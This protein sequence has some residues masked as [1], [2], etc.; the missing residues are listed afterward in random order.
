MDRMRWLATGLCV[1]G[2]AG[3]LW[4]LN[5]FAGQLYPEAKP[6]KLAYAPADAMPPRVDMAAVQR[7]WPAS[8]LAPGE[9]NRLIAYRQ[10]MQGKAPA[11]AAGAAG[12]AA[13]PQADLGTLLTGADANAG[14][15]KAQLCLSCHDL[16]QGGPNRIGPNLWG[17]VGRPVATHA[18]FA[19]S[20]AMKEHGGNWSYESLFA[21][22]ASPARDVP[23]TKMSFAGLRRPEDRAAVIKYL[24]TLGNGAPP[25]PAPKPAARSES[26]R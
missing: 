24:A 23:G 18:G 2:A 4:S 12:A 13:A 6:G 17:V 10:D 5:W 15:A 26:A 8:L 14:K 16:N 7:D 19:Y 3:A 22:L 25:P 20:P 1:A 9:G 21:F 11:P